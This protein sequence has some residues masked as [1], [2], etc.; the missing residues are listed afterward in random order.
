MKTRLAVIGPSSTHVDRFIGL[1]I[2]F[3]DEVIYIGEK[4]L[5]TEHKIKQYI[6]NFRSKNIFSLLKNRKKLA[7]ILANERPGLVHIQ[8]INRV[9]FIAKGVL[10]KLNIN[11][12]VTAWG[13]D[14]LLIPNKNWIYKKMTQ[15]VLNSAAAITVDSAE[16]IQTVRQL[17]KNPTISIVFFGI[18]PIGNHPK[19]KLIFSNRA[20]YPIYRIENI[21][22]E[23]S[24]FYKNHSDFSL[25]I[26]GTG[27]EEP[28]L[29]SLVKELKLDDS[30]DFVGWLKED[31]NNNYY[32]RALIYV[33][34][35]ISDGTSVSLL[36]AM[37]AG[38][39]PVV[40]NLAVS[41]E[42]IE[43]NRN[44]IIKN[45]QE[46]SFELAIQLDQDLV[47]NINSKIICDRA[48]SEIASQKLREI[49][50]KLIND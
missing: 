17:T 28:K 23:F 24:E 29:K 9:A 8:Q 49:H 25:V 16:M 10:K 32:K 1:V 20:L 44:G 14:V 38:C 48:T 5:E 35:P 36:E 2:D 6:I 12:V 41:H 21:I 4:E 7:E 40:A 30:V 26:A 37:S 43:T 13:S 31:Q 11:Y 18:K 33:S 46:N 27:P 42:W 39:I 50:L 3:Y 47:A 19:E 22:T 34:L 15:S 45:D